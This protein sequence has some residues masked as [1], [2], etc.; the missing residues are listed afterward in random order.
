MFAWFI[1]MHHLVTARWHTSNDCVPIANTSSQQAEWHESTEQ[2]DRMVFR[3]TLKLGKPK[4][5]GR[6][7]NKL[8]EVGEKT[9][10]NSE[11]TLFIQELS[12]PIG[13]FDGDRLWVLVGKSQA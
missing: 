5:P 10:D 1:N 6:Q 3:S 4:I 12:E 13:L 7:G 8:Q 11:I 2:K 9:N